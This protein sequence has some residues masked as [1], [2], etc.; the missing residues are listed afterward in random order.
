MLHKFKKSLALVLSV[1]MVVSMLSVLVV[2][3]VSAQT[4][5]DSHENGAHE[6]G[7]FI[8][9][10]PT[11]CTQGIEERF[12]VI[13][14]TVDL[15]TRKV[16]AIDP[17]AHGFDAENKDWVVVSKGDCLT[18]ATL[19]RTCANGCG[20]KETKKDN[21]N[22]TG[23]HDYKQVITFATI[24]QTGKVEKVC[25]LCGDTQLVKLLSRSTAFAD[26]KSG[27]WYTEYINKAVAVGLLKGY[28]DNTVRP[29]ANITRAEAITVIARVAG[30]K[31]SKFS[32][33]KFKDVAKNAWY[34]GAIAWAEQNKIV[35]GRSENT[36]E[37]EEN[38]N[39]QELCTII[40]RY[41]GYAGITLD[42]K[43]AKNTFADDAKIAGFAKEAVYACQRAQLVS[44]RPGNKFAPT[45]SATRAEVAKILVSFMEA[46]VK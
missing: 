13:C 10:A 27:D 4:T 28:E 11:C 36:F 38:I 39:R 5:D 26:I 17:D 31:T 22:T 2:P 14:E 45:A 29:N 23:A 21:T 35:S 12:C 24:D 8:N 25:A 34:N 43:V 41:T 6:W 44:G 37:P 30:V 3:A 7:N 18:P 1:L 19:E 42:K 40:V 9:K 46:Y 15:E 20:H 16:T 32:T 33:A